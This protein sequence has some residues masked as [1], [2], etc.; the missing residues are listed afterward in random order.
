MRVTTQMIENSAK[1][2]GIPMNRVSLLDYMNGNSNSSSL[3]DGIGKSSSKNNTVTKTGYE[4][5]EKEAEEL[6]K[7]AEKFTED[8]EG[9]MFAKAK[10]S[11]STEEIEKA[12]KELVE[13]YND[14]AAAAAKAGG[15]LNEFYLQNIRDLAG[16]NKEALSAVGVTVDK[17][18]KLQVDADKLKSAGVENLEKAFGPGN[19]FASKLA[20]LASRI[21]QNA[22]AGAKSVASNYSANGNLYSNYAG[23]KYDIWG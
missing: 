2:A 17:N 22:E 19:D 15:V 4:K 20:F 3:L 8:G 5:L 12:V 11:G 21:S 10:E 13:S 7:H 14:T 1:R 9:S 23:H 16:G 6:K 18:G